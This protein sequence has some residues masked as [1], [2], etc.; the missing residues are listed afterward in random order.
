MPSYSGAS[1]KRGCELVARAQGVAKNWL[2]ATCD[3]RIPKSPKNRTKVAQNRIKAVSSPLRTCAEFPELNHR[4]FS[5]LHQ[6]ESLRLRRA[7]VDY[8]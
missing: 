2:H 1:G 8:A 6:R 7:T 4:L 5:H 3:Y